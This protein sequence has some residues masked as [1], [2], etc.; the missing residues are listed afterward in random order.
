MR[1][2]SV[3]HG[4]REVV[5]GRRTAG[6]KRKVRSAST[7]A[8]S[9]SSGQ[10]FAALT[11]RSSAAR[12]DRH[13]GAKHVLQRGQPDSLRMRSLLRLFELLG[14]TQK[15]D[16]M[17]SLGDGQHVGQRHLARLIHKQNIDRTAKNF[18]LAGLKG[19][20]RFLIVA[21]LKDGAPVPLCLVN[22]VAKSYVVPA[23]LRRRLCYGIEEATD[24]A[25]S[26][27]DYSCALT[28]RHQSADHL[29]ARERLSSSR[30]SLDRKNSLRQLT[31]SPGGEIYSR[32][33]R[34]TRGEA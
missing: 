30:R 11:G 5:T 7:A 18:D 2:Q 20:E 10:G 14:V 29:R 25:M 1:K 24:H 28:L 22:F 26:S 13:V 6:G 8:R 16:V 32:L 15:H 31:A 4:M 23:E 17:G 34:T 33:A 19:L 12:G 21:N 27:R 3:V 9:K